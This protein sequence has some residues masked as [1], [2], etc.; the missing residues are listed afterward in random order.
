MIKLEL[1]PFE[2]LLPFERSKTLEG[3]LSYYK[4]V[5]SPKII[6]KF[7]KDNKLMVVDE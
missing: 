3:F 7:K 4:F 6:S 2:G 1:V 5:M